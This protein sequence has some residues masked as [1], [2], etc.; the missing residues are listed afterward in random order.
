MNLLQ[1]LRTQM[2]QFD[3]RCRVRHDVTLR[4]VDRPGRWMDARASATLKA[5]LEAL[6]RRGIGNSLDYGIFSADPRMLDQAVLA[7]LYQRSTGRVLAFNALSLM[8]V[9]HGTRTRRV[10]HLGLVMVDPEFRARGLTWL[11]YGLTCVLLFVRLGLRPLWISSVSQVPAIVGRVAEA[12][13]DVHPNPFKAT[14]ASAEHLAL[15]R[16]IAAHHRAVFG[17][18]GEAT[19]DEARF[20]FENAY[21]GGSDNLR[22]TFA[23]ATPHRDPRANALCE[24]ELDYARGDDFLQLGRLDLHSV[25]RY[26]ANSAPLACLPAL[27][28][29][30][31]FA[32]GMR[33]GSALAHS[34]MPLARRAGLR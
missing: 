3:L 10:L 34:I 4:V 19:F 11:V 1:T 24:R 8:E 33:L 7:M 27:C 2:R 12:F 29:R 26:L 30:T 15:A 16:E 14:S 32:L 20:V 21:T 25:W 9:T 23:Q 13:S 28:A 22:K 5:E 18:G 6:V 31:G 17:V